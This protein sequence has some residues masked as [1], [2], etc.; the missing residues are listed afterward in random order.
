M[1]KTGKHFD[2]EVFMWSGS[3]P[4]KAMYVDLGFKSVAFVLFFLTEVTG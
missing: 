1:W 2:E 4:W 3:K